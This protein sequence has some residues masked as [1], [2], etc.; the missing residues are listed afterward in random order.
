VNGVARKPDQAPPPD[1]SP[2]QRIALLEQC[3]DDEVL[4]RLAAKLATRLAPL[5]N[6]AA[7]TPTPARRRGGE[8]RAR[9]AARRRRDAALRLLAET[10]GNLD[11]AEVADRV[12]ARLRR[13]ETTSW[14]RDRRR[15]NADSANAGLFAALSPGL[16]I[17]GPKWVAG[18]LLKEKQ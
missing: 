10:E 3:V 13:Y 9:A 12:V 16:D 7:T 1:Y 15:G 17:P 4:D 11:V 8:P 6:A 2:E 5:L 14:P 18:I